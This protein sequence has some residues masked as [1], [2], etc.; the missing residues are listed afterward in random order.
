MNCNK[1]IPIKRWRKWLIRELLL[2]SQRFQENTDFVCL[3]NPSYVFR[4]RE[5]HNLWVEWTHFILLSRHF[6]ARVTTPSLI[7]CNLIQK[8]RLDILQKYSFPH[9]KE[10]HAGLQRHGGCKRRHDCHFSI[11]FKAYL[12]VRG[13]SSSACSLKRWRLCF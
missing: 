12:C 6:G 4:R 2:F 8:S 9:K 1:V 5:V 11:T 13:K 7:H 10:R 3:T